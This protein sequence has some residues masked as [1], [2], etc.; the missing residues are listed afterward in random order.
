MAHSPTIFD[1]LTQADDEHH[2]AAPSTKA[3]NTHE[4]DNNLSP[5]SHQSQMDYTPQ[6][7]K[8]SVQEL[9][10]FGVLY[11]DNKPLLYRNACAE[12]QT[13]NRILST[14]D[15]VLVVDEVR[16]LAFL[17]VADNDKIPTS[18]AVEV[19]PETAPEITIEQTTA[20]SDF[21][22]WSHPLVRR[23]RLNLQQS[24]LLAILR[25]QYV[26]HEQN[27]GVGMTPAVMDVDEVQSQ[28]ALYLGESGSDAKDEKR[29]RNLL[30]NLKTHGIVS[31]I[32]DHAQ[33]TIRPLITHVASP[34]TLTALLQQFLQLADQDGKD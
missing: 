16:G 19:T 28:L 30:D 33:F 10:K 23:Q 20:N 32:N 14:L 8:Q 25:Q 5:S 17:R 22:D 29:A 2:A 34:Q 12:M 27:T 4:S 1:Q 18:S 31:E 7:V 21:D 24:L 9:L 15:L 11:S 13:I 6:T 3:A 26:V